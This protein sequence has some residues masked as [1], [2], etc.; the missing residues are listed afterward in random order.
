[1]DGGSAECGCL[2]IEVVYEI[3]IIHLIKE[4]T[5]FNTFI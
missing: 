2:Y 4:C 5:N 3:K 1:M